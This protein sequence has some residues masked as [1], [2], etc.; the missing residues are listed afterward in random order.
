MGKDMEDILKQLQ[1]GLCSNDFSGIGDYLSDEAVYVTE[2][3]LK[4]RGIYTYLQSG[5]GKEAVCKAL[6]LFR[7]RFKDRSFQYRY[8]KINGGSGS[9]QGEER[10]L[11]RGQSVLA[12]WKPDDGYDWEKT[13]YFLSVVL[14]EEGKIREIDQKYTDGYFWLEE[15]QWPKTKRDVTEDFL[16]LLSAWFRQSP[17]NVQQLMVDMAPVIRLSREVG[18]RTTDIAGPTA[19]ME[20]LTTWRSDMAPLLSVKYIY[21]K[22]AL[23]VFSEDGRRSRLTVKVDEDLYVSEIFIEKIADKDGNLA[24]RKALAFKIEPDFAAWNTVTLTIGGDTL[25][26]WISGTES[27]M[28]LGCMLTSLYLHL[29]SFRGRL[30][31]RSG[32]EAGEQYIG[33]TEDDKTFVR[34]V[35]SMTSDAMFKRLRKQRACFCWNQEGPGYA[36]WSFSVCDDKEDSM[37]AVYIRFDYTDEYTY[38]VDYRTF[39]YAFCK[40][41]TEALK[42]WG[43]RG[44]VYCTE[45]HDCNMEQF[46]MLKAYALHRERDVEMETFYRVPGNKRTDSARSDFNKEMEIFL[47]DM[48]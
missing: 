4:D 29:P 7:D 19:V 2:N 17:D 31:I 27:D 43:I 9:G 30:C 25:D 38:F 14:D 44:Y 46:I 45:H 37:L 8:G 35:N 48:E 22:G 12:V 47:A 32:S 21:D 20:G 13:L 39:C 23:E 40:G 36:Y 3:R 34:K 42:K 33:Y 24:K 1:K 26:F 11:T 18:E 5:K 10:K 16:R 15:R 41:F 28:S 6:K